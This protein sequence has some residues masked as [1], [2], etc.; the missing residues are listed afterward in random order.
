[1]KSTVMN[2][3]SADVLNAKKIILLDIWAPWCAPCRG[4]E[5]I[6]ESLAKETSDWV[7]IIK[8]DASVEVDLVQK[9]DVTSLPTFLIFKDCE[10]VGSKIGATSKIKLLEELNKIR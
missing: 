1:M 2:S 5:P 9:L 3:F 7:E 6:L 10:I 8:L 4:M